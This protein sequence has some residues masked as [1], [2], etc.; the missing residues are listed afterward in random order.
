MKIKE[1]RQKETENRPTRDFI[2]GDNVA[3]KVLQGPKFR[4]IHFQT[5]F[6]VTKIY[7][8]FLRIHSDDRVNRKTVIVSKDRVIHDTSI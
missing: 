8:D 5:G 7:G 3:L 2:V 6:Q 1:L 4:N